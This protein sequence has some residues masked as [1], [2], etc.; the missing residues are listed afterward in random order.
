MA[1]ARRQ[2]FPPAIRR[3]RPD[4]RPCVELER[5]CVEVAA[6]LYYYT[7]RSWTCIIQE[8]KSRII[9]SVLLYCDAMGDSLSRHYAKKRLYLVKAKKV[10]NLD[11]KEWVKVTFNSGTGPTLTYT[12]DVHKKLALN[13]AIV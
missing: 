13:S 9:I 12:I 6:L 4:P 11:D 8:F 5:R 2:F 1:E 3:K 7:Q 10:D